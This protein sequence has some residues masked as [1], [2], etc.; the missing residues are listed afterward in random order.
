MSIKNSYGLAV[1]IAG[2]I[3]ER[4]APKIRGGTNIDVVIVGRAITQAPDPVVAA[5]NLR[6][7]LGI[8]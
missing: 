5:K 1:A 6:R 8:D 4:V 7:L 3:D 2:G